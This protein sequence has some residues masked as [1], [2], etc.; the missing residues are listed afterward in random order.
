MVRRWFWRSPC[1]ALVGEANPA[2]DL[3]VHDLGR[4]GDELTVVTLPASQYFGGHADGKIIGVALRNHHVDLEAG[5]IDNG[6]D[7]RVA[8]YGCLLVDEQIADDA[9]DGRLDRQVVDLSAQIL[10]DQFLGVDLELAGRNSNDSR[11]SCRSA[12]AIACS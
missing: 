4:N 7:R 11:S 6:H 5:Q 10:D 8:R 12:S 9:A 2:R 3:V 1:R